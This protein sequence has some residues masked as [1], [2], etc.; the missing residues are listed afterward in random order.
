MAQKMGRETFYLFQRLMNIKM[1]LDLAY[2]KLVSTNLMERPLNNLN[3]ENKINHY[4][5]MKFF[6]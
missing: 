6:N 1:L 3:H 4:T 2:T 5:V